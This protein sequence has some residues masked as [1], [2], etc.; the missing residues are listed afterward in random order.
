L[1]KQGFKQLQ[2]VERLDF[3]QNEKANGR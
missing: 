2:K 1:D 3:E